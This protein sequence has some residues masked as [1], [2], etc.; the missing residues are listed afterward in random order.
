[1][2]PLSAAVP[3]VVL[4]ASFAGAQ[5][6]AGPPAGPPPALARIL[7]RVANDAG[8]FQ[9]NI[10]KALSRETLEQ[11]TWMAPS[12]FIARGGQSASDIPNT[13]V[14]L[15]VVVSDYAAGPLQDSTAH[16]VVELRQVVSVDGKPVPSHTDARHALSL[17]AATGADRVR[18]R[19][20]EDFAQYGLV[21]VATDYGLAL[22]AFTK[23]GMSG[24]Q[25]GEEPD[26]L[27]G[28]ETLRSISWKQITTEGGE[29]QFHGRQFKRIPL[30]GRLLVRKTDSQPVQIE[31]WADNVD[32]KQEI[33]DEAKIA[34]QMSDHGFLVPAWIVH[35]HLMNG[36]L[37]TENH[38]RYEPFRLFGAD[39]EIKFTEVPEPPPPPKKK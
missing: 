6:P 2:R 17:G 33:R 11:R 29:L 1:M 15:R 28:P 8:A 32:N 27:V 20:L 10:V 3:A 13:R 18:K 16:E 5:S 25:F 12:R 30:A 14:L 24:L 38:Y 36:L 21:D 4:A 35:R 26:R 23:Q 7:S 22:L 9:Q 39:A 31:I 34:Y 37:R 19:M